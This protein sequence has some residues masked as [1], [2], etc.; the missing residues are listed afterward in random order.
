MTKRRNKRAFFALFAVLMLF[1]TGCSGQYYGG[2]AERT[3][4]LED[5][6]TEDILP[7]SQN[8]SYGS[9][10]SAT[11]YFR[12]LSEDLLAG[13]EQEFTVTAENTIEEL[14]VQALIDGPQDT[15]LVSVKEQSGYLSV[16]LSEKFLE[17]MSQS[18]ES[19]E[20]RR[21]LAVQSIVNSITSIGNYSRVL[22]LI[23][24]SG[25]GNGERLTYAEAGWEDKG[26][27]TIEPLS[28]D[29][30]VILTPER[31]ME[32]VMRSVVEKDYERLGYY[33]A[34]RDYDGQNC[35]SRSEYT[36][37]LSTK[38]SIVSFE[39]ANPVITS[40]N[41]K[42]AA[43]LLNLTYIDSGGHMVEL[44]DLP[45]RMVYQDV[46]KV[47]FSSLNAMFPEN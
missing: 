32:I 30:S 17:K 33:L 44:N 2:I 46:W 45:V 34:E 38:P 24:E 29:D 12:Y 37:L 1:L 11:L 23:D 18:I 10:V 19:E 20:M 47:S 31:V 22:I 36:E 39:M 26:E 15:E 41:G 3:D 21:R 8:T 42:H 35:P 14:V 43:A 4:G 28:L 40:G 27:R 16:T 7:E 25:N 13:V 5:A 9:K 6:Y